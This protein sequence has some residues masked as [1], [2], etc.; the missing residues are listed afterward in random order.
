MP[1]HRSRTRATHTLTAT[2]FGEVPCSADSDCPEGTVCD[3][4][5][6]VCVDPDGYGVGGTP[7]TDEFTV[8]SGEE[9]EY[10][11]GGT[12]FVRTATGN[13]VERAPTIEGRGELAGLLAEGDDVK[14]VP[15]VESAEQLSGL[16]IRSID[17]DYGRWSRVGT[18]TIEL[19]GV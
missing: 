12:S 7:I 13:R 9:V 1:R 16:E 8:L 11:S 14:L 15:V 17:T 6:G 2:R 5:A 18:A 3:L 19:G 4:E 10:D